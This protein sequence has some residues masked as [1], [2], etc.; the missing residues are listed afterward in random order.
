MK[1]NEMK[2]D[3]FQIS[4]L[5]IRLMCLIMWQ[6]KRWEKN[7]HKNEEKYCIWLLTKFF[8]KLY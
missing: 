2:N 7:T 5:W 3:S 8:D 4:A 1:K 6:K